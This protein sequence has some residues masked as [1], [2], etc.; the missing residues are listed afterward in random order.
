M[1]WPEWI[2]VVLSLLGLGRV[3]AKHGEMEEPSRYDFRISAVVTAAMAGLL[4]WGG[5]F[6]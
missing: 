1:G 3:L 6:S 5:F 2:W 4:Y